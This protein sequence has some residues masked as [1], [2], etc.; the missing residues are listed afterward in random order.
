MCDCSIQWLQ[1]VVRRPP[2]PFPTTSLP[3][4]SCCRT[5]FNT[6]A[7]IKR[8]ERIYGIVPFWKT[9]L[10]IVLFCRWFC[11]FWSAG[12]IFGNTGRVCVCV[13]EMRMK[14]ELEVREKHYSYVFAMN[15]KASLPSTYTSDKC[16]GL[17]PNFTSLERTAR[18]W[19]VNY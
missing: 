15:N 2:P 3:I 17:F 11:Q 16:M 5:W 19:K 14:S 10:T 18:M 6:V 1:A 13:C 12:K 8:Y 4:H 9:F 7:K